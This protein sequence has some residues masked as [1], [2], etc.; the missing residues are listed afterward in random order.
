MVSYRAWSRW[1]LLLRASCALQH[2]WSLA[3][4][5]CTCLHTGGYSR[6]W[7][8]VDF[9]RMRHSRGGGGEA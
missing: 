2:L 9:A 8:E 6:V 4:G 3:L 5:T 1:A 7:M